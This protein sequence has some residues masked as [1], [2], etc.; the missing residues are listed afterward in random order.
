MDGESGLELARR[1]HPIGVL[2][3]VMLPGMDGWTVIER[4]KADPATR[5]IPVH[6]LSATED[7]GRGRELGAVGFLTKP[8]TREA[9]N[10]AFERLLHFA[11][12]R[13]RHLLVVDDDADA[14]SA[15]RSC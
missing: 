8:V 5:H 2:L 14:R 9:I 13:T 6:F 12:G 10:D 1:Y 11:R 3:D 7:A 4:L 15:V